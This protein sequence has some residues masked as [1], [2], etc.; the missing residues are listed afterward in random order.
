MYH[1]RSSV[2]HSMVHEQ[3]IDGWK[4]RNRQIG[5]CAAYSMESLTVWLAP[6]ADNTADDYNG[7]EL[8]LTF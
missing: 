4:M 1:S 8:S 5:I 6:G 2:N 7:V 3:T